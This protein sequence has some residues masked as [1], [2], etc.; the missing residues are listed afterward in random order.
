VFGIAESYWII[1]LSYLVWGLGQTFQSGAD[2][3]ILYDSLKRLGREDEFQKINSRLWAVTSTAVLVA[4]LVGA[5][6]AAATNLAVPILLSAV[7]AAAAVP[8]ALSMHEPKFDDG[9]LEEP[10]VQMVTH[11]IRDAWNAPA[12]RYI[13]LFS[14]V[15][16]AM[17]FGPLIFVQPFLAGHDIATLDLGFWQAPVRAAG[18]TGALLTYRFVA[19]A[20]Q[21]AAF[22]ALPLVMGVSYLCIAGVDSVWAYAA[23]LPVGVVAG[24]QN[25]VL[26]SYVN[27][28]IPSGR[29]A[30]MLSVQSVVGS[31]MI[32]GT[33]LFAGV[34]ADG[35]GLRPLFFVFAMTTLAAGLTVLWLWNRAESLAPQAEEDEQRASERAPEPV[36]AS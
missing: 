3:A 20:G 18:V 34:I 5:P 11:G 4:I 12:L 22:F 1:I 24:M 35:F 36:A 31:V 10:Y 2:M 15:M 25:P 7:I 28:R 19:A 14:G 30:T 29:R 26:A 32:A 6:I 21:R 8:L 27:K 17:T 23:F 33:E 9:E 13:M 16:F